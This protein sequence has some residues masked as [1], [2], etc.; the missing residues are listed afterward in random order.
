MSALHDRV[1]RWITRDPDA[2]SRAELEAMLST[3]DDVALAERF[4]GR[5]EFGTAGLRGVVG[6]GPAMMNRLVISETSTGLGHYILEEIP[7]AANRGVI[8]AYDGRLDSRQFARDA[9]CAFAALGIKVYL[10]P[11]VAATPVAAWGVITLGA[12]AGVVVTASHNPPQYNGYKVYWSNGAQIIPPHDAGIAAAIDV[13]ADQPL[14]DMDFQTAVDSGLIVILDASFYQDY[15]DCL[16]SS[17]LFS[18][19]SEKAQAITIAYTAMHGVGAA[20]AEQLLAESGFTDFHSVASQREPDGNF[21]T[22]AFPNPE[23][24]GA[25]DAV[26]ALAQQNSAELACANDPDADRLAV[27]VRTPAGSYE[28]LS[29]DMVGVLLGNYLLQKHHEFVPIVCTTIVSSRMLESIARQAN[30]RFYTTLTGFKWLANVALVHED[31]NHQFLFAYEEALGYAPGRQVRDKDGLAALLAFAQ[32][33]A[34]L[35]EQGMSVLDQ[36][37]QL[38]RRHGIYLSGQRSIALA[39]DVTPLGESLR[40][41]RLQAIAGQ[42]INYWDDLATGIRTHANGEQDSLDLPASDVLIYALEGG[43]RVIV[44][45]SGTEPK[46]KCYYEVIEP[47]APGE[48]YPLAMSRA[49][50]ALATL[51]DAPLAE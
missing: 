50:D 5:L 25:M 47:I 51:M 36:L 43:A 40:E 45:P 3:A 9:A 49:R 29:G 11:D 10:T 34:E 26:I 21:P 30:A 23:E 19:R 35:A 32:M 44:R 18:D 8:V 14:P 6:A 17:S 22:V 24:P 7:D 28:M 20:V 1:Q 2:S 4:A 37:E 33:T 15:I 38:Y 41:R 27:A 39:P 12:A 48:D 46:V 31:N 42:A 13:A 16:R